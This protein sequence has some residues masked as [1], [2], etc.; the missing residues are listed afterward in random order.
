VD[1]PYEST[2]SLNRTATVPTDFTGGLFY[3][4]DVPGMRRQ[5]HA[6]LGLSHHF[7]IPVTVTTCDGPGNE[8]PFQVEFGDWSWSAE[9]PTLRRNWSKDLRTITWHKSGSMD[10]ESPGGGTES[11]GFSSD[12]TLKLTPVKK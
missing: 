10:Y 5:D 8:N 3:F 11:S 7:H 12:V 2:G 4:D 1:C 9:V 6:Q